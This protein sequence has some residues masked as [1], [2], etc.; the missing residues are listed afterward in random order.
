[1]FTVSRMIQDIY[2]EALPE[3]AKNGI[4]DTPENRIAFLTGMMEAW[5]EDP[6]ENPL[7]TMWVFALSVELT[8]LRAG[9]S[10]HTQYEEIDG[11]DN[12]KG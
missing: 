3:M 10:L 4:E 1:M 8:R 12:S 9:A 5:E 2:D 11:H 7:K 6:A